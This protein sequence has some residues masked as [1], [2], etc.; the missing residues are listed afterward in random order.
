MSSLPQNTVSC[1]S[2][3]GVREHPWVCRLTVVYPAELHCVIELDENPRVLGR[4]VELPLGSKIAHRTV[5]RRHLELRWDETAA[6]HLARDLGSRNG[7]AVFG[8]RLAAIPR[9]LEDNTVLRLGDVVLVYERQRGPVVDA[10][11]VEPAVP[12]H[13]LALVELRAAL[14]RA[15]GDPSPALLI[16]ESGS[17]K[18]RCAGE[19]HRLS[20]RS[21][22]YVTLNCAALSPQLIESQLY[23]HQ[24]GAFTG[25]T[26]AQAGLFRAAHGGTL[27]LDEIGELPLELQPK[28]LRAIESG[29]IMPLGTAKT[30]RVD[31]RVVA[32]TN[33][34]LEA[35][36]EA[37]RFRR[38]LY[39]RLALWQLEVPPLARRRVDILD[40]I[41]RLSSSWATQ[42]GCE[43]PRILL[44]P[45]AAAI[46]VGHRW[47]ENLRGL[48]RLIHELAHLA[49]D[50]PIT[51]GMLP[52]WLGQSSGVRP[53][54]PSRPRSSSGS[55]EVR[56]RK[57]QSRPTRDELLA[58]LAANDWNISA[59]ARAYQ[60]DRKQ[61]SR[62]IAMY[63]IDVAS[64][65]RRG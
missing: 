28:L 48:H 47:P 6:R 8:Q 51:D 27:F 5:S 4:L 21:G 26:Q 62:W 1:E 25:A 38:D 16:G 29:E 11:A 34:N 18:E 32:A 44:S 58:V 54:T 14:A 49:G 39:A 12:G 31:V 63:K 13:A 55:R 35:A 30:Q 37:G 50:E 19:L 2:A 9:V 17:G 23:G 3:P 40:W 20:F 10:E 64:H 24:R 42:R 22:A 41:A 15:A 53:S 7:S 46:V 52:K 60:R 61:L 59:T 65:R 36:V 33:R 56:A 57:L 45:A 43:P